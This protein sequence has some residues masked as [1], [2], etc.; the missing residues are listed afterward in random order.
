MLPTKAAES[1][2]NTK[3]GQPMRPFEC[4]I[5]LPNNISGDEGQFNSLNQEDQF[6]TYQFQKVNNQKREILL[7][8]EPMR[9]LQIQ[10]P[11][12]YDG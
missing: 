7:E 4:I 10:N 2:K 12:T 5:K 1:W 6:I 8:R 9:I 11:A 3:Y